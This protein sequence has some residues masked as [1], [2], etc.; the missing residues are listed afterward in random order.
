[1]KP[2]RCLIEPC[3]AYACNG[4]MHIHSCVEEIL[5]FVDCALASTLPVSVVL[6]FVVVWK[7]VINVIGADD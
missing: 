1:M 5:E 2:D 6:L 3:V 7:S 4:G